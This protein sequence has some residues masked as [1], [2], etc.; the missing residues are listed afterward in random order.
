MALQL[1]DRLS[2]AQVA[3]L[4]ALYRNEWWTSARQMDDVRTMLA[5]TDYVFG[6]VEV[7][8][9]GL[10][11]FARVLTDRVYKALIL[12]VIVAPSH[13][14]AGLARQLMDAILTHPDL[15]AVRHFE[16]YCKPE[17]MPLYRKWGFTEELG[18]L[19]FMRRAM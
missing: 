4:V 15:R 13:R 10:V 2:E 12:D 1:I 17:L 19:Q 5:H 18:D 6:F 14:S 16:L 7:E 9:G 3:D 8:S 11:G